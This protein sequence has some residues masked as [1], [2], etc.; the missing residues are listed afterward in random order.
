MQDL[1]EDNDLKMVHF[2]Q[3]I[4]IENKNKSKTVNN[5]RAEARQILNYTSD[6]FFF[7]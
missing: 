2:C 5:F 1:N 7:F 6:T 4:Y 3:C